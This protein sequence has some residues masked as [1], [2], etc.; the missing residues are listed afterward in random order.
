[1]FKSFCD[2]YMCNLFINRTLLF[3]FRIHKQALFTFFFSYYNKMII[4]VSIVM[5]TC[6]LFST[7]FFFW[8]IKIALLFRCF[9]FYGAVNNI[10]VIISC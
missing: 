2:K 4:C 1:M 8:R 5:L 9:M 7:I 6:S 10:E 3:F